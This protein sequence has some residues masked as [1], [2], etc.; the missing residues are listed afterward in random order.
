MYEEKEHKINWITLF[1]R[2]LWYVLVVIILLILISLITRCV[3]NSKSETTSKAKVN[4]S[5]EVLKL[6]EASL[7]YFDVNNLP[8][9]ENES[10]SVKLK[11]LIAKDYTDPIIDSN[12]NKCDTNESYSE[13]TREKNNYYLVSKIKCGK[14]TKTKKVYI[15]CFGSCNGN[16]CIGEKEDSGVCK[17]EEVSTTTT[18]TNNAVTVTRSTSKKT[19][20]RTTQ[21]PSTSTLRTVKRTTTTTTTRKTTPRTTLRTTT[22]TTPTTR[23]TTKTTTRTTSRTTTKTT[24]RTTSRT[25]TKTT[26]RTTSRTTTKSTTKTT[27]KTTKTTTSTTTRTTQP[28]KKCYHHV[29]CTKGTLSN[30]NTT[31]TYT[32]NPSKTQQGNPITFNTGAY[33]LPQQ[34]VSNNPGI[35]FECV[36]D[37]VDWSYPN[38]PFFYIKTTYTLCGVYGS[39]YSYDADSNKCTATDKTYWKE[40]YSYNQNESGYVNTGAVNN[41]LCS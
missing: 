35:I 10:R 17:K 5:N 21:K 37:H 16:I 30:N 8:Q 22:K 27:T 3:R 19:T 20:T 11:Y 24:T 4:L 6:Q 12:N 41:S 28:P 31:C 33:G 7:K 13:V 18:T 25:T 2:I 34:C 38:E 14:N 1:K 40:K 9:N 29:K 39:N 26:T 32:E 36:L 23:T 15:G